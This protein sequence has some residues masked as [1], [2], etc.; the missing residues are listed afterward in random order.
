V[1]VFGQMISV[2][3]ATSSVPGQDTGSFE[4]RAIRPSVPAPP[5]SSPGETGRSQ[6]ARLPTP[7]ISTDETRLSGPGQ[8]GAFLPAVPAAELPDHVQVSRRVGGQMPVP[9]QVVDDHCEGGIR[10][11]K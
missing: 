8:R 2:G 10:P 4:S 7:E 11:T 1:M 3:M 5:S 9:D 6:R